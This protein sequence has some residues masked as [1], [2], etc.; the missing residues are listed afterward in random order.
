MKNRKLIIVLITIIIISTFLSACAPKM[1]EESN[2]VKN[3]ALSQIEIEEQEQEREQEREQEQKHYNVSLIDDYIVYYGRNYGSFCQQRG[4]VDFRKTEHSI[5]SNL[6]NLN[7]SILG[8]DYNLFYFE[9]QSSK[10]SDY[11]KDLYLYSLNNTGYRVDKNGKTGKVVFFSDITAGRNHEYIS[12]VNP[13][14]SE[15]K[16]I[17]YASS[18]LSEYMDISTE[19]WNVEITTEK[20]VS[21][22]HWGLLYSI[23]R[24]ANMK[25]DPDIDVVYTISFYRYLNDKCEGIRRADSVYVKMTN[26]GEVVEFSGEVFDDKYIPYADTELDVEKIKD[27][28]KYESDF[29]DDRDMVFRAI[30]YNDEL[31]IEMEIRNTSESK[32]LYTMKV[33]EIIP[34]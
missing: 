19:G 5:K 21:D 1:T 31:W 33:A 3:S 22:E 17:E 29:L 11:G 14:S 27:V 18:V 23:D 13:G 7:L 34:D 28:F 6:T 15:S 4:V 9:T 30:S 20:H 8:K 26:F 12:P 32:K 16:F 25:V 10:I 2:N 24:F